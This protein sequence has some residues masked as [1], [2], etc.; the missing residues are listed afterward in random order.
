VQSF[1]IVE[2]LDVIKH[3]GARLLARRYGLSRLS[4]AKKISMAAVM[5]LL[6]VE[7]PWPA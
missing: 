6:F 4:N 2:P 5:L 1:A 7:T 3:I